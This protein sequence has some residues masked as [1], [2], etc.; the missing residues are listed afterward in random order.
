MLEMDPLSGWYCKNQMSPDQSYGCESTHWC[1]KY[2]MTNVACCRHFR[3]LFA[4]RIKNS[5]VV[6]G[7]S[8]WNWITGSSAAYIWSLGWHPGHLCIWSPVSIVGTVDQQQ[9]ERYTKPYRN[10]SLNTCF[11]HSRDL[12]RTYSLS[13]VQGSR[14]G[15]YNGCAG[16]RNFNKLQHRNYQP[17]HTIRK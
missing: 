17:Y 10:Y 5:S 16:H 4:I 14:H 8:C 6:T 2:H 13:P 11:N 3:G 12:H 1:L 7:S 9:C 15:L